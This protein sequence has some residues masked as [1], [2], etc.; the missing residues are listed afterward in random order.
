VS[1]LFLQILAY[2]LGVV[3]QEIIP[4]PSNTRY[5]FK[6]PDNAFWRFMNP[7]PFSEPSYLMFYPASPQTTSDLKEHVAITI[8][9]STAGGSALAISI[10]AADDLYYG[11]QP[12]AGVG[13]FT[14]IGSQLMG[15]GLGGEFFALTT[16]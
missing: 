7:G 16:L 11:I 10:F 2:I 14:L 6:T 13:I 5:G 4:G 1:Q 12:N 3:M 15:Y 8:F 9:A